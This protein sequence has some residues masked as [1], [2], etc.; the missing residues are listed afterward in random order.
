MNLHKHDRKSSLL[1]LWTHQTPARVFFSNEWDK[2][3]G[4]E[5]GE[6]ETTRIKG[7]GSYRL[8][9]LLL[10]RARQA[11]PLPVCPCY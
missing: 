2:E 10:T 4:G 7:I 1:D 11:S 3:D 5:R 6:Q 8:L 9:D